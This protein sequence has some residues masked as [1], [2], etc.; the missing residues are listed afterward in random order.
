MWA[1]PQNTLEEEKLLSCASSCGGY[2]SVLAFLPTAILVVKIYPR[3]IYHPSFSRCRR[4]T[5]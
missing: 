3:R 5:V 1:P 4:A 2:Q